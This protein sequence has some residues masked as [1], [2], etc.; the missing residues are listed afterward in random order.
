MDRAALMALL[1]QRDCVSGEW[2]SKK[3]G[4]TRMAV[5]KAVQALR[6]GGVPIES[7][8]RRGY[9]LV[10]PEDAIWPS[11]IRETLS[12]RWA[13]CEIEYYDEI[14]STNLRAK[15]LGREGAP[16]GTL[17]VADFQSKGRGRLSRAWS[18]APGDSAMMSLL[19]RPDALNPVNAPPLVMIAA[20][21]AAEACAAFCA[22]ARIKWPND[23]VL[24]GKKICGML[25]E[26]GA[27]MERVDYLTVGI[28]INVNGH[29]DAPGI[30][31]TSLRAEMAAAPPR[32]ALIARVMERF[33]YNY[34][35]WTR[36]GIA[37]ILA[38]YRDRSATLGQPIQVIG[39]RETFKGVARDIGD[40]GALIVELADGERAIVREGD[41]SVRGLMGYV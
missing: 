19:L 23:L 33:E 36:E 22:D 1:R 25:L 40:D 21:S 4:V 31:A 7:V 28:G 39:A 5:F 2:I 32:A 26:M 6:D 38:A 41:V 10:P 3:L 35:L 37:P 30:H 12:T 9:R 29:P 15:M 24:N 27:D 11:R 17:V 34:D 18:S 13:G 8:K 16:H 20:V 14:D